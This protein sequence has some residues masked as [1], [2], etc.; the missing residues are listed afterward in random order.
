MKITDELLA[1]YAEGNVSLQ[2]RKAVRQYLMDNPD[3]LESVLMMMDDNYE[4]TPDGGSPCNSTAAKDTFVERLDTLVEELS[5]VYADDCICCEALPVELGSIDAFDSKDAI[6]AMDAIDSKGAI[7]T[8]DAM[9]ASTP[10]GRLCAIHCEGIA[11]RHFGFNVS[12]DEL[13]EQ[14]QSHG[15]LQHEGTP[16]HNIGKLSATYGLAF[17]RSSDCSLEDIKKALTEDNVVIAFID[18]GELNGD[19]EAERI[20]DQQI[21]EIPDHAVVICS[22]D[23]DTV[24]IQDPSSL[25]ITDTYPIPQF[26]D[27]WEDSS[28]NIII[29]SKESNTSTQ[30]R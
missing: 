12:D 25:H 27:A 26:M 11:L 7:G 13:I 5:P 8:T 30:R 22:V 28:R 29:I 4:I 9:A 3:R 10:D 18:G 24:T 17:T 21:G 15:W 20:E 16:L 14:S 2:E 23:T 1:S 19:I 6:Y